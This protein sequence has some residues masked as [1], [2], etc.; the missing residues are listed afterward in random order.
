VNPGD[1]IVGD[2]T[3]VVCIPAGLIEEALRLAEDLARRDETFADALRAGEHFTE[4][5]KRVKCV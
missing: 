3:G 5:V 1:Y 4:V 2:E